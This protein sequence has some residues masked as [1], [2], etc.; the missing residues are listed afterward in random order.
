MFLNPISEFD[1]A[2]KS[3]KLKKVNFALFASK[4]TSVV[5]HIRL[6]KLAVDALTK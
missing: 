3:K 2:E 4:K 6:F 5:N 1:F